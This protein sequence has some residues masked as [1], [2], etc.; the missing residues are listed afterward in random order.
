MF[1]GS[2]SNR[3]SGRGLPHSTTLRDDSAAST[4]L[5]ANNFDDGAHRRDA[6]YQFWF[7]EG[8]PV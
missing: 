1:G 7:M 6:P 5:R 8:E 3:I 4:V 2:L